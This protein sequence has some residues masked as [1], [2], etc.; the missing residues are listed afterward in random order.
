MN[1]VLY[2]RY[3]DSKQRKESI[4]GQRA[5]CIEYADKMGYTI[6]REYVDEAFSAKTV[7][8]PS[9]LK[10]IYDS[11][12]KRFQGVLVYQLDRF[13]RSK[14]D[15]AIYKAILKENGVKV[16]S[17]K[18]EISDE[19]EGFV[20]ESTLEMYAEYYSRELA[21]K[22]NRGMD[23]NAQKC[24]SNG[25]STPLGYRIENHRYVINEEQAQIVRE[26]YE[27]YADGWT[28]K[29]ICDS[30]NERGIKTSSG[31]N[32]NRSSLHTI[33]KNRK[34]LG[35]YIFKGEEHPGGMPQIID[36]ELFERVAA[37]VEANKLAP[38]RARAKEE[39][40]LSGKLY[41]GYCKEKMIGHS[42]NQ[43]S[44]KGVRHNYYKCKNS[45]SGKTCKKKLEKKEF[46]E[47]A[48]VAEC[49]RLLSK[50]NIKKIEKEMMWVV[51]NMESK[52]ELHRL[53]KAL[54]IA[55][56]EKENQLTSLR[57]C[58]NEDVRAMIFE[59]LEKI[60]AKIKE[61]QRE[62]EIEKARHYVVT[63]DQVIDFL[64]S[65]A[66]GDIDN[67]NY[68]RALIKMFVN[69]IYLYDDKFRIIFNTS[70]ED[71]E[72]TE[73]LSSEIERAFGDKKLCLLSDVVH[74]EKRVFLSTKRR[75]FQSKPTGR[76]LG[77]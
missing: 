75:V 42:S 6:V 55:E 10:M 41:C 28:A 16:I 36:D 44:K 69:R 39:Y 53:E 70:D 47:K 73:K 22:V 8:R 45:G 77:M 49:R 31:A 4:E 30:L 48:V 67:I 11:K 43:I 15:S 34:Y 68:R 12:K 59:D 76:R 32:F 72:I 65:L 63:E 37:I 1:V 13:S 38:A 64:H 51:S 57:M 35:I 60:G 54:Q 27:K 58:T 25:G 7:D 19:P 14:Y 61:L 46:I 21:R 71:V 9:F 33:L 26:I 56:N 52:E 23:I 40:L 2:L 74:H 18:E 24:L 20:L 66:N 17:A 29:Q 3:S 62:L 50:E 5:A